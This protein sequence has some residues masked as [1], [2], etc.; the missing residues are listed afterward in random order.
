MLPVSPLDWVGIWIKWSPN[1]KFQCK[2]GKL[3]AQLLNGNYFLSHKKLRSKLV[4]EMLIRKE[5]FYCKGLK[6]ILSN[7][8]TG[9]GLMGTQKVWQTF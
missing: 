2:T 1:F 4:A 6:N 7:E 3:I 9:V 5:P 8:G